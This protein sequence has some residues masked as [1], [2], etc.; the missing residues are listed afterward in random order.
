[1]A[2]LTKDTLF[3]AQPPRAETA[4]DKTTRV[5]REIMDGEAEKRQVK[6]QRLR[7]ARLEREANTPPPEPKTPATRSR[8]KAPVKAATQS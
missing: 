1:M 3:K 7:A 8:K 4:M 2:R 5:V 6:M